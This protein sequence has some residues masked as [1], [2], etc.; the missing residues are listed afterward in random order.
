MWQLERRLE[1]ASALAASAQFL[2][3]EV[4][5]SEASSGELLELLALWAWQQG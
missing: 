2:E 3:P 4:Q 1:L 5:Q